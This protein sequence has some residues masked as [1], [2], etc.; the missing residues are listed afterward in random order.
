MCSPPCERIDL[1]LL[2][3]QSI[4]WI[5]AVIE[6]IQIICEDFVLTWRT[7]LFQDG[8]VKWRQCCQ[9]KG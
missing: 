2:L 6:D 9:N 8:V 4:G 5:Q 7:F 3:F 1:F